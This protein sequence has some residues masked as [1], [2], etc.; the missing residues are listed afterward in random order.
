[1]CNHEYHQIGPNTNVCILCLE[2]LKIVSPNQC[3]NSP[4][5]RFDNYYCLCIS[6]GVVDDTMI[7]F[8]TF[9][10]NYNLYHEHNFSYKRLKYFRKK[11]N[12]VCCHYSSDGDIEEYL[13]K[14]KG[15][16]DDKDPYEI[17]IL[18]KKYKAKKYFKNFYEIYYRLF[19]KKIINITREE[20]KKLEALF[21]KFERALKINQI[22]YM[23]N[24]NEILRQLMNKLEIQGSEFIIQPKSCSKNLQLYKNII[25]N[26]DI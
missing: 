6:C 2:R 19:Q 22:K 23:N 1:M 11:L 16:V 21:L 7:L 14:F 24:Y 4:E 20:K 26:I 25:D 8:N 18:L 3:C 12:L 10:T 13:T 9:E 15:L 5:I 17:L